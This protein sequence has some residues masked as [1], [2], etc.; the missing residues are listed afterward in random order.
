MKK[1]KVN[2]LF[3]ML[4]ILALI[5][6]ALSACSKKDSA[7]DTTKEDMTLTGQDGGTDNINYGVAD[8]KSA[9]ISA[10]VN[11]ETAGTSTAGTKEKPIANSSAV[12]SNEVLV[13]SQEKIIRNAALEM[14]TQ[15]FDNLIDT[16]DKEIKKLGG[17]VEN[18]NISG[19]YYYSNDLRYG[20]ITARVPKEKFDEFVNSIYDVANVVNKQESTENVTLQYVDTQSHIKTL[21]VEQSRLLALLEKVETLEDIITLETRLSSVRYELESYNTQLRTYDNLV[22]YSTVTLNIQE[23]ERMTETKDVKKT[24]WNRI[25]SGFSNSIYNISEGLKDF[26]VWFVINLPYLLLWGII[27][28]VAILVGNKYYKKNSSKKT[29]VNIDRKEKPEEK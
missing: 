3:C 4:L 18:S 28:T 10:D 9:P 16:L 1:V 26:F 8:S 25:H 17:Y 15:D 24:V 27:I 14:E 21:E 7:S 11:T 20:N 2:Y 6:G 23:V 12:T 19:K 5:M 13:N 22:N 29:K